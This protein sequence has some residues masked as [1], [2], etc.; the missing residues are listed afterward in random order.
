MSDFHD[1]VEEFDA[2]AGKHG[3]RPAKAFWG[4]DLVSLA[5]RIEE[6]VFAYVLARVD[7]DGEFRADLRPYGAKRAQ[8]GRAFRSR[9]PRA[10][11]VREKSANRSWAPPSSPPG[12]SP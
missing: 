1:M 4:N 2:L 11:P 8:A 12:H 10:R 7:D 3:F 6:R 9:A 5:K